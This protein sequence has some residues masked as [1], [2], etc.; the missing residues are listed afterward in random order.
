MILSGLIGALMGLTAALPAAAVA[1]LMIVY[2]GMTMA[3]SASLTAGM[4][5][6]A[7]E[8]RRGITMAV[9]SFVGF[10]MAFLGPLVFGVVLGLAG[11]GDRG[12]TWAFAVLGLVAASGPLWM[13]LAQGTWESDPDD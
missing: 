11:G 10:A 13:R 3:D 1:A 6:A 9:Y 7:H 12:W 8:G 2:G 5:A 4:V